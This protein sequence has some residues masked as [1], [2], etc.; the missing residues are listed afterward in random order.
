MCHL[1]VEERR[2]AYGSDGELGEPPG[3]TDLG[4]GRDQCD[5]DRYDAVEDVGC[6]AELGRQEVDRI[7]FG[8]GLDEPRFRQDQRLGEVGGGAGV[9]PGSGFDGDAGVYLGDCERRRSAGRAGRIG[10]RSCWHSCC[11]CGAFDGAGR[12]AFGKADLYGGG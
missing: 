2:A 12:F 10:R 11:V 9:R 1:A 6:F 8:G 7:P 4:C 3:L 5:A